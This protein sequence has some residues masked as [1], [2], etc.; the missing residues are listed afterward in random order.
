[1]TGG[2]VAPDGAGG[3]E[4]EFGGMAACPLSAVIST[5]A[6]WSGEISLLNGAGRITVE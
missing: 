3:T 5:A 6:K 1:M 4:I 2:W